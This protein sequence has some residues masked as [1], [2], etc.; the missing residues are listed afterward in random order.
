MKNIMKE[1]IW[2]IF[3]KLKMKNLLEQKLKLILNIQHSSEFKSAWE[4]NESNE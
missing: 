2:N 4:K 3:C 1:Y